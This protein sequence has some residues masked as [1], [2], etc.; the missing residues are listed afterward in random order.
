MRY[1]RPAEFDCHHCGR[2]HMDEQFLAEL[3]E[4]R[5][6]CGFPFPITSGY[7]CPEH[8]NAVS[9]TGWDGPH[10]TGRAAD[11]G[12]RGAQALT[13]VRIAIEMGFTGIGIQ[14]K[15][16]TR[17]IHLDNLPNAERQPRPTIWSYA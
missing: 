17:F 1:F 5:H 6:R 16:A 13:V 2:N 4:L 9:T 10:T 14:Q 3:D 15:G 7:R 11:I 8:N 12:V